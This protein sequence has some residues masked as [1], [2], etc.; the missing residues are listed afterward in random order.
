ME[1]NRVIYS[2]T[3]P[4]PGPTGGTEGIATGPLCHL[5]FCRHCLKL[6]SGTCVSHEVK[7]V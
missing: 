3:H 6:R 7:T 4:V 2:S 5:Y 1:V